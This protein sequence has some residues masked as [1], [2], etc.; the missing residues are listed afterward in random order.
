MLKR[1]AIL[2]LGI[3]LIGLGVLLFVA[4][5]GHVSLQWLA[6]LWPVFLILAGL[7][8]VAGH[9]IDRHPR[10]PVSGM[11][12]AAVGGVL[13]AANLRGDHSLLLLFGQY[14]FWLLL[15]FII[16]RVLK[17]YTHHTYHAHPAATGARPRAFSAGAIVVMILLVGGGLASNFLAKNKAYLNG[18]ESKLGRLGLFGSEFEVNAGEQVTLTLSPASHLVISGFKG[19]IEVSA[20]AESQ[21]TAQLIARIRANNKDEASQIASN[22]HLQ[23]TPAGKNLQFSINADGVQNDYSAKLIIVLPTTPMGGVEIV[24]ATGSIKLNGLRG[25]Q[26]I[27][28]TDRVEVRNNTGQVTIEN[29]RSVELGQIHG[30]VSVTG[31]RGNLELRAVKGAI[32]LEARGGNVNIEQSSGPVQARVRDAHLTINDLASDSSGPANQPILKL[33]DASNT[34]INLQQIKGAVSINAE[35][36]R[37]EAENINGDLTINNSSERVQLN[38]I[39]GAL[40]VN[41][42]NSTVEI[43]EFNG[44]AVIEATRDVTVRGFRGPL[45]VTTTSGAINLSTDEKLTGNLKATSERGRIRVS[46]PE[47]SDFKLDAGSEGGRVRV[48]GFEDL[49]IPNRQKQITMEHGASIN[50]F[51]VVL[52]SSRGDVQLQ[53]SGLALAR[54]NNNNGDNGQPEEP[55]PTPKPLKP[56]T[57]PVAGKPVTRYT[58]R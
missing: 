55:K 48:R 22:I 3:G 37:I 39:N 49:N 45:S 19:D 5:G 50:S 33:T 28:D 30:E 23:V 11:M 7:V 18:V 57:K 41:T 38:Q 25:D 4:P 24:K 46:I 47:D 10:S 17:Q 56:L 27:R 8:Q 1:L 52:R 12:I 44:A 14:W 13:L 26:V 42:E 34:S 29:P 16:G 21:P 53:S 15:A 51:V 31:A 32:T 36:S 40:K 2:L 54:G 35:R 6:K 9:L 20:T 43:E 58:E